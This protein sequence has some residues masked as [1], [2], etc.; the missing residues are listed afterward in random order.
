MKWVSGTL[1]QLWLSSYKKWIPFSY[2][3]I[4][5]PHINIAFQWGRKAMD[6]EICGTRHC[7]KK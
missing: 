1:K 6:V 4:P 7:A 2:R 5:Q 3:L